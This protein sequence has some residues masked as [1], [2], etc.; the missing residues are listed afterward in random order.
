MNKDTLCPICLMEGKVSICK[1]K[2]DDFFE[3]PNC[4]CGVWPPEDDPDLVKRM[5]QQKEINNTYRSCSLPEGVKVHGGGDA[6]GSTKKEAMKK[7]SLSR[8][9]FDLYK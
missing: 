5:R 8:L 9:S 7:K 3:C 4:K 2:D 6:V 1:P